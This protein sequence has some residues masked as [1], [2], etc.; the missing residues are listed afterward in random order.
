MSLESRLREA[1]RG[2][3]RVVGIW[4]YAADAQ[5]AVLPIPVLLMQELGGHHVHHEM[6]LFQHLFEGG[7]P[8][9]CTAVP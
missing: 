3:G 1:S 8:S 6:A 4:I 9:A 2:R 7:L 5:Y